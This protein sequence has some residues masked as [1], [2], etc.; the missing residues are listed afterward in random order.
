[1]PV[2]EVAGKLIFV[3]P[4]SNIF[5]CKQISLTHN[6]FLI[7][8]PVVVVEVELVVVVVEEE[9]VGDEDIDHKNLGYEK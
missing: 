7:L 8:Y 2:E 1:L 4:I 9:V 3:F 6:L 5:W